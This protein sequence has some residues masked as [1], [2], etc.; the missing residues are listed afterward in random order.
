MR[1]APRLLLTLMATLGVAGCRT[2]NVN[3]IA[4]TRPPEARPRP[5]FQL[6]EFVAEYNQNAER[7]RTLEAR[8]AITVKMG[9]KGDSRDGQVDGRLAVERPRNF[10]LELSHIRS[11]VADIG[12]N[13]ERFWFWVTS[14]KD[15]S[16]YVCDYADLASTTLAVTYQ[17]DWIVEA[18]G[19]RPITPDEAAQIKVR[20]GPEPGTTSLTFPASGNGGQAYN[21]TMIVSDLTRRVNE[22]RV[23]SGDGKT[24]IAQATINTYREVPLPGSG[25]EEGGTKDPGTCRVPENIV[26]DWKRE[27][28]SLNVLLKDVKLN[29]FAAARRAAIFVE[30]TPSGYARVNL[31]ELT[32]QK[33]SE[34]TTAIRESLP[35]PEPSNRVRLNPPLQIRGDGASE[36]PP[37]RAERSAPKGA[38]LLPVLNLEEVVGAPSPSAPGSPAE[39]TASTISS[40]SPEMSIER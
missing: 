33:E 9:P 10:K 25:S 18:M 24:M 28:L 32:R 7:I 4:H 14:K 37:S 35:V 6:E 34:G 27:Q 5:S 17:P 2:A 21:R 39:R 8:P 26:L 12:S 15:K 38:V 40:A 29:Q 3:S 31:A 22:F 16:V 1:I 20:P 36:K 11:T 23:F 30:P 13:D 19:L